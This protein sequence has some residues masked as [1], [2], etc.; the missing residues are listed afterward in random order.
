MFNSLKNARSLEFF[1]ISTGGLMSLK[2]L[3]V[4]RV[5]QNRA[6]IWN[7][8][9]TNCRTNYCNFFTCKCDHSTENTNTHT[10]NPYTSCYTA[11][12]DVI[13]IHQVGMWS[14]TSDSC[15]LN[16]L[17]EVL[18]HFKIVAA[19]TSKFLCIVNK[20]VITLILLRRLL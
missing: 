10:H 12:R 5:P 3:M 20:E 17:H 11:H 1:S 14:G 9:L 19:I 4:T 6:E 16:Q 15:I 18:E 8:C 2:T 7:L 13:I